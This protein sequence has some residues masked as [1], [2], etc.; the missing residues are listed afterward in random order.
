MY[1]YT[2]RHSDDILCK[3]ESF[4]PTSEVTCTTPWTPG[5]WTTFGSDSEEEDKN[6]G[7]SAVEVYNKAMESLYAVAHGEKPSELTSQ[8][9]NNWEFVSQKEKNLYVETA[10]QASN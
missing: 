1:D 7:E 2:F 3:E 5:C 4:S 10:T 6:K 8:L 9:Q